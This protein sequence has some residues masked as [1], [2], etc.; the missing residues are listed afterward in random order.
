MPTTLLWFSASSLAQAAFAATAVLAGRG[1]CAGQLG[2]ERSL[3]VTLLVLGDGLKL[4]KASL[5]D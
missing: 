3:L 2:Q 5:D 4:S 1:R